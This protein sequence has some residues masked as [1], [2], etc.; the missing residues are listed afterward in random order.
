MSVNNGIIFITHFSNTQILKGI[1]VMKMYLSEL[2]RVQEVSKT[3]KSHYVSSIQVLAENEDTLPSSIFSLFCPLSSFFYSKYNNTAILYFRINNF[4]ILIFCYPRRLPNYMR[5]CILNTVARQYAV[6]CNQ[7]IEI[8][9]F[10]SSA[11]NRS[12]IVWS[13]H[14][15]N[16]SDSAQRWRPP[17]TTRSRREFPDFPSIKS[18]YK[19]LCHTPQYQYLFTID[20]IQAMK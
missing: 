15:D 7:L 6:I 12:Y 14:L 1:Q 4:E 11:S 9:E 20:P 3:F 13:Q 2:D 8:I 10:G 18:R 19:S 5:P 17:E 16:I